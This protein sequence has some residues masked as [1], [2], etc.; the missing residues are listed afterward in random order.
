MILLL[1]RKLQLFSSPA[2]DGGL[3]QEMTSVFMSLFRGSPGRCVILFRPHQV[4]SGLIG[5]GSPSGNPS[6]L[7]SESFNTAMHSEFHFSFPVSLLSLSIKPGTSGARR[8]MC[9]LASD[10]CTLKWQRGDWDVDS[11]HHYSVTSSMHTLGPRP[12][13]YSTGAQA[14][15]I[16]CPLSEEASWLLISPG[17][18]SRT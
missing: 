18:C 9:S 12:C 13:Y 16:H 7:T 1:R 3:T 4:P 11:P 2:L 17:C 5:A 6:T 14:W 15:Q 8:A 10:G